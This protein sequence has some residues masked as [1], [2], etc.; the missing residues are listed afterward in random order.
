MGTRSLTKDETAVIRAAAGPLEAFRSVAR[1]ADIQLLFLVPTDRS[2]A[3]GVSAFSVTKAEPGQVVGFPTFDDFNWDKESWEATN[4]HMYEITAV[5]PSNLG[6]P[7]N[8]EVFKLA[9][10]GLLTDL[11][12]TEDLSDNTCFPDS[13]AHNILV[14]FLPSHFVMPVDP[15]PFRSHR[16]QMDRESNLSDKPRLRPDKRSLSPGTYSPRTRPSK[17]RGYDSDDDNDMDEDLPT[18][19]ESKPLI[20]ADGRPHERSSPGD[21]VMIKELTAHWRLMS[22]ARQQMYLPFKTVMTLLGPP[23]LNTITRAA[24]RVEQMR[25]PPLSTGWPL[26][27]SR[28]LRLWRC[29]ASGHANYP[30]WHTIGPSCPSYSFAVFRT[31]AAVL[32]SRGTRGQ[33]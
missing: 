19:R 7:E 5:I 29:T 25:P 8:P 6:D 21:A 22:S 17:R 26:C 23:R 28:S 11:G 32:F 2:A 20:D 4:W 10:C 16:A 24:L 1:A 18:R 30:G 15:E 9:S 3:T 12:D 27:W 13:G 14:P 31:P 33:T